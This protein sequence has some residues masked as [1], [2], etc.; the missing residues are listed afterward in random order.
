MTSCVS[1]K[2]EIEEPYVKYVKIFEE[3]S[4]RFGNPTLIRDLTIKT[5][6]N[7][8]KG[9]ICG[10]CIP[11]TIHPRIL[12]SH[13]FWKNYSDPE[14]EQLMLHEISHCVLK[15]KHN[16]KL[17]E[18]GFPVSIMYPNMLSI[19]LYTSNRSYYLK[20]LFSK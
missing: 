18:Y 10:V 5:V 6:S 13:K 14:R 16:S 11:L 3:E 9:T 17:D 15:R 12:I 1:P 4:I 2:L 8:G 19:R 7:L 20:E